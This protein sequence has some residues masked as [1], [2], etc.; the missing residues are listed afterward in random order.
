M[1]I[2]EL[3]A[4][5]AQKLRQHALRVPD[6]LWDRIEDAR[7]RLSR[8]AYVVATLQRAVERT[9]PLTPEIAAF[10]SDKEFEVVEDRPQW[11]GVGN[12]P[13]VPKKSKR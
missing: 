4:K 6:D 9:Q 10:E 13:P 5:L 7:G 1:T 12:R 11:G 3:P 8:N 2:N